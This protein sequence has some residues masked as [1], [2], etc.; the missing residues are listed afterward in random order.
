LKAQYDLVDIEENKDV[1]VLVVIGGD[2]TLL[3]NIH[4][5]MHLNIPFYQPKL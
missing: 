2:G 5:W 1:D 3:H 4:C